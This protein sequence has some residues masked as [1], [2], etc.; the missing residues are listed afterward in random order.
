MRRS[1]NASLYAKCEFVFETLKVKFEAMA[2]GLL[3]VIAHTLSKKK[4]NL[5]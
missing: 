4:K 3:L 5:K 2:Q 1:E